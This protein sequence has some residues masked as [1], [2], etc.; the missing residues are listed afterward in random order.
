MYQPSP[1]QKTASA[2]DGKVVINNAT[3]WVKFLDREIRFKPDGAITAA[4]QN[5][6]LGSDNNLPAALSLNSADAEDPSVST[7]TN[8]AGSVQDSDFNVAPKVIHGV[9]QP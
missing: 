6:T 3:K 8:F 7:N 5:I 9:V 1:S 4:G 2:T